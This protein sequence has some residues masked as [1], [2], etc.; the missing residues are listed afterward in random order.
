MITGLSLNKYDVPGPVLE[1]GLE[2]Y[3]QKGFTWIWG[4][5]KKEQATRALLFSRVRKQLMA[6][7]DWTVL[8]GVRVTGREEFC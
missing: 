8:T 5:F 1:K 3:M 4:T 2:K 7:L 6:F